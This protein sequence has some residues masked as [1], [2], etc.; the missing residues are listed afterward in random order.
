VHKGLGNQ[1]L[2]IFSMFLIYINTNY[3]HQSLNFSKFFSYCAENNRR[4]DRAAL[5]LLAQIF[6][7]FRSKVLKHL[8]P[9]RVVRAGSMEFKPEE[10]DA[11]ASAQMG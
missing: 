8:A 1:P 9:L 11:A 3:S 4:L 5:G 10:F 7:R 2:C 6:D